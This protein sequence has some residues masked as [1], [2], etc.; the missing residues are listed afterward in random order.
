MSPNTGTKLS[1]ELIQMFQPKVG[2]AIYAA[3]C[4]RPDIAL[5]VSMCADHLV[6]PAMRHLHAITHILQYLVNTQHFGLLYDDSLA[7]TSHTHSDVLFMASDASF[8]DNESR[9]SSQGFVTFLY[10]GPVLWHANKQRSATI[11]TTEAELVALLAAAQELIALER[12]LTYATNDHEL[13]MTLLCD[14]QQTVK[15]SNQKSPLLTTKLR[16][17]DIHQ[18][19]LGE[20][21]IR[22]KNN[23]MELIWVPTSQMPADG[24]TK[25]LHIAKHRDFVKQIG[26]EDTAVQNFC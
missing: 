1:A 8:G 23:K 16:H 12:F 3:I 15:I 9:K 11:S 13:K 24:F 21:L 20:R 22:D 25:R 7:N 4:T 18:H 5:A 19:W 14:N 2:S 17:I 26:I 10:G 6:N